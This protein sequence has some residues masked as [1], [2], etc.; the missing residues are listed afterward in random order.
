MSGEQISSVKLRTTM[1][2]QYGNWKFDGEPTC[3]TDVAKISEPLA[4]FAPVLESTYQNGSMTMI[5]RSAEHCGE[6]PDEKTLVSF[7]SGNALLWT[8]RLDN[9][10]ELLSELGEPSRSQSG[11]ATTTATAYASWGNR[12]FA[13]LVGD[14][15][16]AV[17]N[18]VS[19]SLILARDFAGVLPLYYTV[20]DEEVIWCSV[21]EPLIHRNK[22]LKLDEEYLAGWLAS[23][24]ATH[25]TPYSNIHSVPP[26]SYVE[27]TPH[28]STVVKY[29]DLDSKY[30]IRY[31]SDKEYEEHFRTLFFK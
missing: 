22:A 9:R 28:R 21:L 13:K 14:W 15:T 1:S 17:W 7:D 6:S 16:A 18:P 8:G 25:L 5:S 19:R 2:I 27:I 12:C 10:I 4:R 31:N 20:D 29:W 23:F 26:S 30:F 3:H 24:P 11:D